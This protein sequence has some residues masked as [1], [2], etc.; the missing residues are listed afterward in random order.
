MALFGAEPISAAFASPAS[1][2]G[3]LRLSPQKT[4]GGAT[5]LV[6]KVYSHQL[7]ISR[8]RTDRPNS[9]PVLIFGVVVVPA[10]L[11]DVEKFQR[12]K[13]SKTPVRILDCRPLLNGGHGSSRVRDPRPLSTRPDWK[14]LRPKINFTNPFNWIA[15]VRPEHRNFLLS[16]FQKT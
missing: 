6:H 9:V 11:I 3:S 7:V 12:Q 14:S 16:F 13:F 2:C 8:Q 10:T 1:Q 4:P 15:F 5:E